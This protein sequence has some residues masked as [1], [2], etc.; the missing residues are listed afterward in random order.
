M[1]GGEHAVD[2]EDN[3]DGVARDH[4]QH[5]ERFFRAMMA[6]EVD[7]AAVNEVDEDSDNDD[8]LEDAE[9]VELPIVPELGRDESHNPSDVQ[10]IIES[11]HGDVIGHDGTFVSLQRVLR[12]KRGW[13]SRS[14]M[15]EDIDQFIAGCLTC[16]K[17]KKRYDN[18][19]NTR[20]FIEGAPFSEIS[21]CQSR[22]AMET[23]MWL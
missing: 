21:V 9:V 18:T 20:F 11:V 14:K 4:P 19:T 10:K 15:L 13:A 7:V 3:L 1:D 2:D 16:Q 22:T 12:H 17:F 8:V 5:D 23:R 6:A